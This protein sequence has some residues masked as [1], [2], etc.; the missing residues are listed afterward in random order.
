MMREMKHPAE[1]PRAV[2]IGYTLM[3][4]VYS[5]TT[6]VA[7]ASHGDSVPPFLPD[8]LSFGRPRQ[9]STLRTVYYSLHTLWPSA[10]SD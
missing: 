8:A 4:F 7:Y 9:A 3:F 5:A 2:R 1:F 6:I 10:A